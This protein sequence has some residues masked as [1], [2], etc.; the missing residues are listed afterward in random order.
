[1]VYKKLDYRCQMI[2]NYK[3]DNNSYCMNH[4]NQ[5]HKN[6][7]ACNDY[8]GLHCGLYLR[9]DYYSDD[10]HAHVFR[11]LYSMK[12]LNLVNELVLRLF[13]CHRMM[14]Y[15]FNHLHVVINL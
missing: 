2:G 11:Y 1:M 6:P 10:A 8:N 13:S 14:D 5:N 3:E 15:Y 4:N 9:N 7:N 12:D